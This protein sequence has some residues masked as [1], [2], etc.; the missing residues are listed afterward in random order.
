[1]ATSDFSQLRTY[2]DLQD[3]SGSAGEA[4]P[5]SVNGVIY[6]SSGS[7][8]MRDDLAV[9]GALA[10]SGKITNVTD[11]TANQD[12]ATKKY[13]DD[14]LT[15]FDLDATTDSGTIDVLLGSETLTV[16]G[17]TGLDTSASGTTITVNISAGGVDTT[18]LAADAVTGAK[19]ADNAVDSEHIAL[20]ALDQEHYGTGSIDSNHLAGNIANAKLANSSVSVGGSNVSLGGTITGANIA[21]ALNSDLGGNFTIGSESNDV[22]SF[23]G[24]VIVGGDLT[25]NGT[26]TSV[27][28]TTIN[29]SSS[30]TFEGPADAHETILHAGG[31]GTADAP[32]ADTT[33]YLPA[34]SAGS[35]YLPVL[36]DKATSAS[37]AVL[38]AEFALLDGGSTVGTTALASGDGFLHNDGGTMK[39]TSVDKI[40][41]FF[42]GDALVASSGVM[43]VNVDDTGIEINSDAIRLKD[44]GVVTAKIADS[45]VT[46]AKLA[47]DAVTAAKLA[48]D[49]V[50]TANIVDANVT[51]AKLAGD[52]VTGAKIADNAVDSEHIALGALDQEHYSTGSIDSNHLAGNIANAK[53][54]NSSLSIGGATVSLGGSSTNLSNVTNLDI[55]SAGDLQIFAGV[56]AN[57]LTLGHSSQST[58]VF[59]QGAVLGGFHIGAADG[60]SSDGASFDAAGSLSMKGALSVGANNSGAG[61]AGNQDFIVF[62]QSQSKNIFFDASADTFTVNGAFAVNGDSTIVGDISMNGDLTL[63]SDHDVKARAF[64]TYSDRELKTNIQPMNNALEK[65]MKLEAVSYDLKTGKKNEIGFIAQDVAKIA[66]EVCAVDKNGIGRGIDYS[67]M[68]TLLVGALKAQQTQIEDLKRVISKL[69][70]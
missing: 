18:Q 59:N 42:A 50:V 45:N 70:K 14:Q 47:A 62:G 58:V 17:G 52:A 4:L 9:N 23:S 41:D 30:F 11:P 28:S 6:Y 67:R 66:P 63:L 57:T 35:Y 16:A 21:A 65:V 31:D 33:I 44:S 7:M 29:I 13:V 40:A 36:A 15:A 12:A 61:Q 55:G 49:A 5:T 38:A 37:A 60:Y 48:D 64:I 34:L 1:M 39:Q 22:A 20:G 43:A 27:N 46:T 8:H 51:T 69:Q 54:A 25:V 19:I 56:G 3:M 32:A 53:L 26:T 10:V 2:L 68:S 24:G